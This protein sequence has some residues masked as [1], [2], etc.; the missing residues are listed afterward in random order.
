MVIYLRPLEK[1]T[2][3]YTAIYQENVRPVLL[4]YVSVSFTSEYKRVGE[5]IMVI[6]SLHR[7]IHRY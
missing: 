5:K 3:M 2:L 1:A 4:V 7:I 6:K